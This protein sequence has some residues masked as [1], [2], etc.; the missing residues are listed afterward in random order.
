MPTIHFLGTCSGTEPMVGTHHCSFVLEGQN[1]HYW[2]DAGENCAHRAYTDG[3]DVM[4]TRAILISHPHI[5][6]IGG[7]PNLLA[8]MAKLARRY[9]TPLICDNTLELYFPDPALLPAVKAVASGSLEAEPFPF[10][11]REH[12]VTDGLLFDDSSVRITAFHNRHLGEDGTKGYH[13][14]S[15]RIETEGRRIVYSGDVKQPCELDP[16]IGEG[17]DLLIMET[18][19]HR[20]SDVCDYVL[21]KQVKKLLFNHHGRE[22][23]GDRP[24]AEQ[25]VQSYAERSGI[26]IQL[27]YDGMT[28]EV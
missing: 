19:H 18:G 23:L 10:T 26:E 12:P 21:E 9:H 3:I 2:F 28:V 13:S 8:C 1:F 7:L 5:D 14:Y 17:C 25:L 20:V 16:V 15:F 24:A 6:H 22:I 27:C 11:L 4:R